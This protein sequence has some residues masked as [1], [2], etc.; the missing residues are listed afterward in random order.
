[1]TAEDHQGERDNTNLFAA[2][3]RRLN[4]RDFG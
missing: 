4:L 3:T 1:V 2:H